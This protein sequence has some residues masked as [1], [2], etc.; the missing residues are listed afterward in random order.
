M[1]KPF[2]GIG[3]MYLL[4][5]LT[6]LGVTFLPKFI[7]SFIRNSANTNLSFMQINTIQ[8]GLIGVILIVVLGITT[9][10]ITNE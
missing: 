4:G 2:E 8:F 9:G 10:V 6:V 7:N 3:L 1:V 5:I